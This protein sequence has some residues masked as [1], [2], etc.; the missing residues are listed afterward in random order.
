MERILDHIDIE[1]SLL[2]S[3]ETEITLLLSIEIEI[4]L[5]LSRLDVRLCQWLELYELLELKQ[6]NIPLRT[7]LR[8]TDKAHSYLYYSLCGRLKT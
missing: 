5:M 2:L 4:S 8:G 3:I 6:R 1:I 7:R